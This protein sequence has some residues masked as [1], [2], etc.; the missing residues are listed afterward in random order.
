MI[1][2]SAEQWDTVERELKS[3]AIAQWQEMSTDQDLFHIDMDWDLYRALDSIGKLLTCTA[4]D[5]SRLVGW[6]LSVIGPHP[7]YRSTVFGLQDTYYVLPEYR[8]DPMTGI[9]L[10][11]FMEEESRRRGALKLVGNTKSYLDKS[12]LF[13][14]LKWRKEGLIYTKVI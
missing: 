1:T 12:P 5:E 6:H 13:E 10:F 7:H 2:F 4:R 8:S 3:Y 9:R 14:R 11:M